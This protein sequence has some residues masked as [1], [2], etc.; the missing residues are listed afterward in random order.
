MEICIRTVAEE[1]SFWRG[2]GAA[3]VSFMQISRNVHFVILKFCS[4][5]WSP[6]VCMSPTSQCIFHKLRNSMA[7]SK[8]D[9]KIFHPEAT[10]LYHCPSFNPSYY[11]P[12]ITAE[13]LLTWLLN[14]TV[15]GFQ[16]WSYLAASF[17][18]T[19]HKPLCIC[20][21]KHSNMKHCFIPAAWSLL[22]NGTREMDHRQAWHDSIFIDKHE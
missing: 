1:L 18:I 10:G 22:Q 15:A 5:C 13:G 11:P 2:D 8:V 20:K 9:W 19:L 3:E 12:G 16:S 17:Q 7:K 21:N 4:H 6:Q 14:G